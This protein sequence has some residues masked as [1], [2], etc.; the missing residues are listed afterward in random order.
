MARISFT[1][2]HCPKT[3]RTHTLATEVQERVLERVY[4]KHPSEK[5]SIHSLQRTRP[6]TG[7][8]EHALRQVV[9]EAHPSS[10]Y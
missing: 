4:A 7:N 2:L 3:V 1:H 5:D 10:T 8:R 6:D 9:D